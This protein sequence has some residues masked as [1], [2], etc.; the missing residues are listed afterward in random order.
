[1]NNLLKRLVIFLVRKRLKIKAY[2]PFQFANQK[3]PLEYYEFTST[4]LSK[5]SDGVIR[6]ANVS[7]NWLLSD[8]CEIIFVVSRK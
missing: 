3:S 1:M 4:G 8:E 7:L 6:P 2:E 5:C